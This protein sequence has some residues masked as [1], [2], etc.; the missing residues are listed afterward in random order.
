LKR[1][2]QGKKLV[3]NYLK[4]QADAPTTTLQRLKGLTTGSLPTFIDAGSN[5]ASSSID[6]DNWALQAH[7]SGRKLT[8]MGDDTWI[9]CFPHHF[10]RAYPFPS[11]NVKD[12]HSVDDGI[13]S[14]IFHEM[15]RGDWDILVAHFLGV[16]HCGHRYGPNHPG[17]LL[18]VFSLPPS[19]SASVNKLEFSH[20]RKAVPNEH[21]FGPDYFK[22]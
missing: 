1:I 3:L 4:P 16:D 15:D 10:S 20:G 12:L 18:F 8:F 14:L 21:P 7:S 6:E 5:F 17:R 22:D 11:F 9:S 19:L 2:G 13:S